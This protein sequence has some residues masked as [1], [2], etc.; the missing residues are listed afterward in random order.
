MISAMWW[1]WTLA[2]CH[3]SQPIVFVP[4]AGC[5]WSW[6]ASRPSTA[7]WTSGG[8]RPYISR[9]SSAMF[10]RDSSSR[11]V[12]AGLCP[13]DGGMHGRDVLFG[14]RLHPLLTGERRRDVGLERRPLVRLPLRFDGGELGEHI[15]GEEF[16]R[17]ADVVVTV[18]AG[19]LDEDDLVD[20]DLAH[21]AEVAS[22]VGRR[23]DAARVFV[24]ERRGLRDRAVDA[25]GCASL[26]ELAPQ[27]GSARSLIV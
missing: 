21:L 1:S 2:R 17:R 16:E 13:G 26:L 18:A 22:R 24:A 12:A 19:L 7:S 3:A 14:E 20:T 10:M 11:Q 4:G 25:V 6:S 27:I 9:R 8:T 23:S 15:G 5:Q